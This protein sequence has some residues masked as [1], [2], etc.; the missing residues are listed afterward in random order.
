MKFVS[1]AQMRRFAQQQREIQ[2]RKAASAANAKAGVVARP[3][4]IKS[5]ARWMAMIN[6]ILVRGLPT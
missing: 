1:N 5:Q 2:I 3:K 6:S 4:S